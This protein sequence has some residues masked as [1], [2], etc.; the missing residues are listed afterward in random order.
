MGRNTL[1]DVMG[2]AL[3]LTQDELQ[4]PF[5]DAVEAVTNALQ[6]IT[7]EGDNPLSRAEQFIRAYSEYRN[8]LDQGVKFVS[9]PDAFVA[10]Y[11]LER[12]HLALVAKNPQLADHLTNAARW[13]SSDVIEVAETAAARLM[14]DEER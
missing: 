11:G 2:A 6:T 9:V 3:D 7:D 1:K 5:G 12:A 13:I 8:Q 4:E 14:P 10:M